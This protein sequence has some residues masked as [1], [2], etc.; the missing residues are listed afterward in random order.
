[1]RFNST[2]PKRVN[3]FLHSSKPIQ[4]SRKKKKPLDYAILLH[5]RFQLFFPL[6]QLTLELILLT[7]LA[8]SESPKTKFLTRFCE[9]D[10]LHLLVALIKQWLTFKWE[11]ETQR[12][13]RFRQRSTS[14]WVSSSAPSIATRKSS[15]VSSSAM[16][17]MYVKS[18]TQAHKPFLNFFVYYRINFPSMLLFMVS[19]GWSQSKLT[20]T[21]E[22]RVGNFDL[23]NI[24]KIKSFTTFTWDDFCF[25]L[26]L[27]F[28]CLFGFSLVGVG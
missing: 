3:K 23:Y 6:F 9:F 21:P 26:R 5:S 7:L 1:M 15:F 12:P 25:G 16:L 20:G 19:F 14:F 28:F 27:I 17:L 4:H 8:N 24:K 10:Y 2:R 13:S 11:T 22:K 18:H